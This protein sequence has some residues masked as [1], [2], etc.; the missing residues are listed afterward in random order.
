[1]ECRKD[2]EDLF[3]IC[4]RPPDQW[5]GEVFIN[6]LT[7]QMPECNRLKGAV[8]LGKVDEKS[9]RCFVY[10]AQ[11]SCDAARTYMIN[12]ESELK[13]RCHEVVYLPNGALAMDAK[14]LV[15]GDACHRNIIAH[16]VAKTEAKPCLTCTGATES[17]G[18][19]YG[20]KYLNARYS[21]TQGG[22]PDWYLRHGIYSP[23]PQ[24][25]MCDKRF[26]PPRLHAS[27]AP[28]LQVNIGNTDVPADA[29]IGYWAAKENKSVLEAH[30]AYG[31]FGNSGITKC[32]KGICDMHINFPGQYTAEGEVHNPHVHFAV[33]KGEHWDTDVKTIEFLP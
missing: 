15:D 6:A 32:H 13:Q 10:C 2:E 33:W 19:T 8:S 12:N 5:R 27:D 21:N 1:M 18:A 3:T 9:E 11:H 22:I 30:E 20:D 23:L 28:L 26:H 14:D 4:Q 17:V 29:I 25:F 24:P 31:D 16:N 7:E